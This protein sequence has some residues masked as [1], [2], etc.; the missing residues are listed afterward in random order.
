MENA[1][2][3]LL[4][5]LFVLLTTP[6]AV[7]ATSIE[8]IL[9]REDGAVFALYTPSTGSIS[10]MNLDGYESE[11]FTTIRISSTDENL[12]PNNA[13]TMNQQSSSIPRSFSLEWFWN[14]GTAKDSLPSVIN[15]PEIVAPNTP[16]SDLSLSI[17]ETFPPAFSG[18][19]STLRGFDFRGSSPK[20]V[21]Q[22]R[23]Y[24]CDPRTKRIGAITRLSSCISISLA[25]LMFPAIH[26]RRAGTAVIPWLD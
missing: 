2:Y 24:L 19:F 21:S 26:A 5:A 4:I 25:Q 8:S 20:T 6:S 16:A 14:S 3:Y 18:G 7:F 23:Q 15:L 9:N 12:L 10:V 13:P 11:V 22:F 1:K 17:T